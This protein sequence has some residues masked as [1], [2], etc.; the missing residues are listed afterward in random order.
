[1][2]RIA[3]DQASKFHGPSRVLADIDLE[4]ADHETC[5]LVGPS[6]CGRS[7]VLRMVAG[8]ERVTSGAFNIAGK[9]SGERDLAMSFQGCAPCPTGTVREIPGISPRM[10]GYA[11]DESRGRIDKVARTL[12]LDMLPDRVPARF[13]GGRRQRVAMMR[14]LATFLF[15][16]P[17]SNLDA[18][19]RLQMRAEIRVLH[20]RIEATTICGTHD[21]IEAMT[22]A[23]RIIVMDGT[24]IEQAGPPPELLVDPVHL[25]VAGFL[26]SPAVKL[27][28]A[29]CRRTVDGRVAELTDG[30]ALAVY[31]LAGDQEDRAVALRIRPHRLRLVQDGPISGVAKAVEPTGLETLIVARHGEQ[32]IVAQFPGRTFPNPKRRIQLDADPAAILGLGKSAGA[33][34]T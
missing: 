11:K 10:H 32:D 28:D 17:P 27:M 20:R 23:D 24:R 18:K 19:L 15:D 29:R 8:L 21:Q 22:M 25:F 34:L 7:T 12:G 9:G 5:E 13:S 2:A 30:T 3:V 16:A 33:R 31:S 14:D 6:G 4:I 1:M 26:G